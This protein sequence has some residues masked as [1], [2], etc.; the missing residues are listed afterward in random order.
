MASLDNEKQKKEEIETIIRHWVRELK[1]KLGWIND[2]DRL[3]VKY[4]MFF[5]AASF[6]MFDTFRLSSKSLKIFTGHTNSVNSIDYSTFDGS[7]FICSG[8]YDRTVRVWNVETAKETNILTG[9]LFS[10]YCVKF[11]PYHY[12][13]YSRNVIC[14]SSDDKSIRFWDIKDHRPFRR[15]NGHSEGVRNIEFSPFNNGRYFC[16]GSCDKTIRLWDV[17]TSDTLHVFNGHKNV[18]YCVDISP[19]Q[20]NNNKKDKSNSIGVI[21]GNGYTM[22]SGSYDTTIRTWDIEMTKQLIVFEGHDNIVWSVKYGSNELGIS[23]GANTILSG[24]SDTSVRL[25]DMRSG[26]Q[27]QVF[28]GHTNSVWAVEYSPFVVD[29]GKVGGSSNVICSGS[30]DN[31]IRFWDIRSN[32]KQLYVVKE[33]H[34]DNIGIV[35]LKF[36]RSNNNKNS[37]Y[38]RC[39]INLCFGSFKGLIHIWG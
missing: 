19:L 26:K 2:F 8:S 32:K 13:N 29:N 4:V 39:G 6:F 24:S 5:F 14:A 7:Q 1:I 15:F 37:D 36:L 34:G 17:E 21:G 23:G 20:S 9:H 33:T 11:S 12:Y 22:C 25:W 18:V 38:S 3:V 31:T 30:K 35:C 27:I 16:S 28:N 10:V